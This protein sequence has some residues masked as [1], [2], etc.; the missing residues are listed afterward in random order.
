MD[1]W[2][3][4]AGDRARW[5]A[6]IKQGVELFEAKRLAA[7]GEKRAIRKNRLQQQQAG[8]EGGDPSFVCGVCQRDCHSRIGLVNHSRTHR[9]KLPTSSS[10]AT[11]VGRRRRPRRGESS[12]F[13]EKIGAGRTD[14]RSFIFSEFN[15]EVIL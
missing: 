7:M 4:A 1:Q 3:T 5:R 14:F 2:E 11:I 10:S 12:A 9:R 15:T 8:A 13:L 6:G